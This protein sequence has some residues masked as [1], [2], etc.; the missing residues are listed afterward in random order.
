MT[1]E[2]WMLLKHLLLQGMIEN[3][4]QFIN[5]FDGRSERTN[6]DR[7]KAPGRLAAGA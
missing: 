5:D 3:G 7:N 2:G 1:Q 6:S 4:R